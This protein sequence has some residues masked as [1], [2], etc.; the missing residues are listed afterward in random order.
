[1]YTLLYHSILIIFFDKI[2]YLHFKFFFIVIGKSDA[3]MLSKYPCKY[4]YSHTYILY[5]VIIK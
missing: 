2:C 3:T 5:T 1:M 4:M